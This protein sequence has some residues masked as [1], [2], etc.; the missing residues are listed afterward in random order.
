[1]FEVAERVQN[2]MSRRLRAADFTLEVSSIP[3]SWSSNRL[4]AYFEKWGEVVHVGVSLNYRELILAI[5]NTHDLR[6]V[7]TDNLL[8]LATKMEAAKS[9][10][11]N[12]L[13]LESALAD[14]AAAQAAQAAQGATPTS[15]ELGSAM[16]KQAGLQKRLAAAHKEERRT[17]A[18]LHKA[19]AQSR[20]SEAR[21]EANE[22]HIKQLMKKRYD[23]TGYAYVTFN[24]AAAA[25]QALAVHQNNSGSNFSS[26]FGG[27]LRVARAPDPE[28]VLWENLQ[29]SKAELQWRSGL[30]NLILFFL[31]V[32]GTAILVATNVATNTGTVVASNF[33]QAVGLWASQTVLIV[34]GHIIVIIGTI[35]LANTLERHRSHGQKERAIMLKV[36]FF[37]VLN[38]VI[39]VS[40]IVFWPQSTYNLHGSHTLPPTSLSPRTLRRRWRDH[41]PACVHTSSL[42][43]VPSVSRYM[44]VT[45]PLQVQSRGHARMVG[46][47]VPQDVVPHRRRTHHQLIGRR[48]ARHRRAHRLRAPARLVHEVHLGTARQDAG[49]HE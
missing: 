24:M 6:N 14:E 5:Q 41:R 11:A 18:V 25:Q 36:T 8:D 12:V 31:S 29:Y 30:A 2:G 45:C 3:K 48:P 49:P 10:H 44:S 37:Q 20:K 43:A 7:H 19:R 1:M 4:R 16:Y 28:D 27:G 38:N 15:V 47:V 9:N 32:V 35:I 21:L 13:S 22:K 23:C 40:V 17:S 34:F 42:L 33:F 26:L 46:H 39:T